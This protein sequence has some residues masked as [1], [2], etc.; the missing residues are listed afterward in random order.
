MKKTEQQEMIL[1]LM[2]ALKQ[3]EQEFVGFGASLCLSTGGDGSFT[4]YPAPFGSKPIAID[5][6]E[7]FEL[8]ALEKFREKIRANA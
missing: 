6:D 7:G 1:F 2:D 8:D 3:I 5:F 4:F